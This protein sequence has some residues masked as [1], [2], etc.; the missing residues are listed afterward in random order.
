MKSF[1]NLLED[2]KKKQKKE[3][4]AIAEAAQD[5]SIEIQ[6]TEGLGQAFLKG[7]PSKTIA[8]GEPISNAAVS[9]ITNFQADLDTIGDADYREF[10]QTVAKYKTLLGE[11]PASYDKGRFSKREVDYIGKIVAPVIAELHP[12]TGLFTKVRFGFKDFLKQFKPLKLGERL[13][14]NVP[15]LGAKIRDIVEAKEAGEREI[16]R[17]EKVRGKDIAREARMSKENALMGFESDSSIDTLEGA[18]RE[19]AFKE[20]PAHRIV[21]KEPRFKKGAQAE[22]Q[23]EELAEKQDD[24]FEE[25]KNLFEV[26]AEN[27]GRTVELL[28]EGEKGGGGGI[29]DTVKDVATSPVGMVAGGAGGVMLAKKYGKKLKTMAKGAIGKGSKFVKGAARVGGRLFLQLLAAISV[30]DAAS[31]AAAADEI[32]GK[33][34]EDLTVRDRASAGVG[35]LLEGLS[36]GLLKKD[37][38]AKWLAGSGEDKVVEANV[39]PDAGEIKEATDTA[40]VKDLVNI[41]SKRTVVRTTLETTGLENMLEKILPKSQNNTV[42]SPN[43]TIQTANTTQVLPNLLNKNVDDTILALKSVY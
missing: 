30:F 42:I 1:Q 28:E 37:K 12:L 7:G 17:A 3:Q 31:S 35:G 13:L 15:I 20:T 33:E 43:N 24:Q 18:T 2:Q 40:P 23:R 10:K 9:V 38:I 39:I 11:L 22:E 21:S 16:R 26:I 14:G 8:E 19:E 4:V 25:N 5:Y 36:F 41:A 6:H 27:T 29:L 34:K 32:L